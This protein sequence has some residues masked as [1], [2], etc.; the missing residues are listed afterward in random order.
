MIAQ[1]ENLT[2][3]AGDAD[4][5]ALRA[6]CAPGVALC[7][8]VGIEGSFSRRVGAQLA[9]MPDG[10]TV[11][12]LSD[13]CLEAQLASDVAALERPQVRRYG[14]GSSKIDFR[15]PCGGGL[16]IL[17]DPAP[18]RAKCREIAAWLDDRHPAQLPLP[19]PS[20]LPSRR[21]NPQLHLRVFGEGP[22]LDFMQRLADAMN[23]SA[24]ILT[25]ADLTLGQP[26]GLAEAD[27]WTAVVL[28]FHDHEWELA[29]IEEALASEA[30]Y[31]GAQGGEIARVSRVMELLAKGLKEGD[32]IVCKH[33]RRGSPDRPQCYR[34]CRM[35]ARANGRRE[36]TTHVPLHSIHAHT[37]RSIA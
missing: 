13:G 15:L 1:S 31:I 36:R 10:S 21:Y 7:T 4:H 6:A 17:L 34:Q 28:L 2:R 3:A 30:F 33:A 16:D 25:K 37:P 12:S 35:L 20:P 9:S 11:G 19:A 23:I 29:L 27:P 32:Y 24:E 22:E 8:I 26:S 18:D 14:S 5:A